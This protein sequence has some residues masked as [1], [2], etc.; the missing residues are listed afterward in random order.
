MKLGNY[1]RRQSLDPSLL[2]LKLVLSQ[3]LKICMVGIGCIDEGVRGK[4]FYI[5]ETPAPVI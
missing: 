2:P 5:L 3:R 4:R 1:L